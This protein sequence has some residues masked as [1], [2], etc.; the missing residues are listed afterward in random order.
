M[1]KFIV[2]A[3]TP[4][5]SVAVLQEFGQ[6]AVHV[7]DVGLGDAD[8]DD[9]FAYAQE[10]ERIIVSRDLDW[11]NLLD[12]PLGSHRGIVVLRVPPTFR[13]EQINRVLRS[14]LENVEIEDL[15]RALAIVEPGRYRLRSPMNVTETV[16][17][18]SDLENREGE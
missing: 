7:R 14:F 2:D 12:Y 9:I 1:P 16:S 10:E 6:D 15:G 18:N 13:A 11:S 17:D 8:D 3:D 4:Y 5:S